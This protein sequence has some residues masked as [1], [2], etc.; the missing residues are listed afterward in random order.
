MVVNVIKGE[1]L[2]HALF[3]FGDSIVDVGNNNYLATTV[4]ANLYPYGRDF[5]NHSPTE[6]FSNGKVASDYALCTSIKPTT[7]K[8]QELPERTGENSWT[9]KCT[10]NY[11]WFTIFVV[12]GSA[13]CALGKKITLFLDYD[14][15]L[16]PIVD[17]PDRTYMSDKVSYILVTFSNRCCY[18]GIPL[19]L[20]PS[21][22]NVVV[23]IV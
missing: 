15:T 11:R 21:A 13:N 7:R 1:S 20:K 9:I 17:N 3:I 18:Y 4:K 5:V 23:A 10:I 8:L 19:D 12:A 22:T 14:E 6:R 2:V 16:S